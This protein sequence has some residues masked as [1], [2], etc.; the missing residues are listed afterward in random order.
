MKALGTRSRAARIAATLI[1]AAASAVAVATGAGA[2][3]SGSARP[4][5][6]PRNTSPPTISGTERV[7]QTLT[8]NPGSWSGTSP[9]TFTYRWT[10]CNSDLANC[11]TIRG[12]TSRQYTL[13]TDDLGRRLLLL[14]T[15]RNADGSETARA[16]TRVIRARGTAPRN[17]TPPTISGTVREGETLTAR[18]GSWSGSEPISFR[19]Q[20]QRCNASGGSCSNIIGATSQTHRLTS[21]DVG[22]TMR[23]VVTARNSAGSQARTSVPT[24]VVQAAP[25]PGP[26]GQ[27][28]LPDGRISV[29]IENVSLPARLIVDIVRFSPNP[30]RSR[31][32]PITVR[33][34]VS[35]TRGF[36]IRGALVSLRSTPLLTTVPPESATRTDGWVVMR[37]TP[38]RPRPGLVFPLR[39]GLNVQFYVQ[40]RKSGERLLFG[41]T[42]SRLVQVRTARPR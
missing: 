9:I 40:A 27:I 35:D 5:V 3:S 22:R 25:P 18:R 23:V 34:H 17:T 33:V 32:R 13:T 12:A 24:A 6:A 14:V 2:G 19:Y 16:S 1:A 20:W 42:G 21:A 38:R 39:N 31:T 26:G 36:V 15:A 10:R 11:E 37:T 4:A 41:V 30:V 7:G 28:R 8:G 29:P